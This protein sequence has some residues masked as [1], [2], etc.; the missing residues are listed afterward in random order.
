MTE[1]RLLTDG[2]FDAAAHHDT[3]LGAVQVMER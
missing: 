1:L 3:V 2:D